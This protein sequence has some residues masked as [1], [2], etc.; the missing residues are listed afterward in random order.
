MEGGKGFMGLDMLVNQYRKKKNDDTNE[1][2]VAW[3]NEKLEDFRKDIM[4]RLKAFEPYGNRVDPIDYSLY[5]LWIMYNWGDLTVEQ[6]YD[7]KK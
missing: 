6:L 5:N 7:K 3:Y 1:N 2:E 4:N